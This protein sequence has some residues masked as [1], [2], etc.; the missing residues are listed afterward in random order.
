MQL[1]EIKQKA[2]NEKGEITW[3]SQTHTKN[4]LAYIITNKK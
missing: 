3:D 2:T 4:G 1:N